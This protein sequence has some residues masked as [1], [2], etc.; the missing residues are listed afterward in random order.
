MGLNNALDNAVIT[1]KIYK[2][3]AS[4][5]KRVKRSFKINEGKTKNNTL[6][7]RDEDPNYFSSDTDPT[8]IRNEK[9]KYMYFN[10]RKNI[11]IIIRSRQP[12]NQRIRPDPDPYPVEI[13][14]IQK[15]LM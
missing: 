15:Y 11:C 5:I 12:K 3:V 7:Y 10:E 8:L 14:Q 6:K 4:N 9:K 13:Y 2:S 1:V